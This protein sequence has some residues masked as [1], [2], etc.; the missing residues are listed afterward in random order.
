MK[1]KLRPKQQLFIN[2]YLIDFNA[3]QAAIRAGYSPHTAAFIGAENLKKPQIMVAIAEEMKK[4]QEK[5]GVTA[6]K[7]LNELCLL[8]FADMKD[9]IEIDSDGSVRVKPWEEMPEGA[10]RAVAEVKEVRRLL[11]SGEGEGKTITLEARLG[12]KHHDKVKALE[13]LGKHLGIWKDKLEINLKKSAKEM[14]DSELESTVR[15]ILSGIS[16]EEGTQQK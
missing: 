9:Y 6:D 11:G 10:S 7:V 16:T 4:R 12:Y 13:L 5:T 3:T 1:K 15:A 2:E 14:D 8:A